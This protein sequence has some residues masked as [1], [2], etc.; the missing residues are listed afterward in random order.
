MSKS[1]TKRSRGRQKSKAAQ[2]TEEA[3]AQ[4]EPESASSGL[5][6]V[7]YKGSGGMMTKMRGGFQAAVG[8]TDQQKPK[9]GLL[10]NIIWIAVIGAAVFF[11]FGQYQ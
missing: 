1:K 10:Y 7:E 3:R 2:A 6:S 5:R 8:T 9:G 11:F 4:R